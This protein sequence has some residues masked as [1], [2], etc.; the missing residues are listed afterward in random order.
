MSIAAIATAALC[1][2]VDRQ[3]ASI[4]P[5]CPISPKARTL[6]IVKGLKLGAAALALGLPGIAAAQVKCPVMSS[7]LADNPDRLEGIGISVNKQGLLE[8]TKSGMP[9]VIRNATSCDLSG[10]ADG[11]D[12]NC[13][14]S[15]GAEEQDK[16]EREFAKLRSRIDNCLPS[17]LREDPAPTEY[18]EERLAEM[19]KQY[20]QSF[21][22]SIKKTKRLQDYSADLGLSGDDQVEISLDLTSYDEGARYRISLTIYRD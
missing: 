5:R 3:T 18:S 17:R 7:L 16:T 13:S 4:R 6:A 8:V 11:L 12:L 2:A 15:F 14:W 1:C 22:D 20:G 10:P 21:V 19:A 9:G